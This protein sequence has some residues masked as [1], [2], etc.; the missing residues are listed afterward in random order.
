MIVFRT[1]ATIAVVE[2]SGGFDVTSARTVAPTRAAPNNP[3]VRIARCRAICFG[4]ASLA[5]YA[6]DRN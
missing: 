6:S 5:E 2:T 3:P 1:A 4:G